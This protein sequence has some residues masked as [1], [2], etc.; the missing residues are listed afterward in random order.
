MESPDFQRM[1]S[2]MKRPNRLLLH[3]PDR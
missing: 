1:T 2:K 3:A